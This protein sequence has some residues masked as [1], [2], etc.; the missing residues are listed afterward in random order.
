[1]KFQHPA[2]AVVTRLHTQASVK[3]FYM[4]N[5]NF[6]TAHVPGSNGLNQLGPGNKSRISGDNVLPNGMPGRNRG[7]IQLRI[8]Q[9]ASKLPA[10]PAGARQYRVR[11]WEENAGLAGA[12]QHEYTPF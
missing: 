4:T 1:M 2:Q 6:Q 8:G 11:Y 10:A 9:A 5:C 7:D 3:H 12:A